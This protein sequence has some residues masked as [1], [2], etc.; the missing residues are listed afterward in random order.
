MM[1]DDEQTIE[2]R[3]AAYI[4][5]KVVEKWATDPN[6]CGCPLGALP[7]AS[8]VRPRPTEAYRLFPGAGPPLA[9]VS[10]FVRGFDRLPRS[11]WE[12]GRPAASRGY[13]L[14]RLYR[15]HFRKQARP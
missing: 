4:A 5:D 8:C 11:T 13:A 1:S 7:R 2:A 12:L 6:W 15:E 14:G 9:W 10:G 3:A